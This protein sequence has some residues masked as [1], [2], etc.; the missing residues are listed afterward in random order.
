MVY[1]LVFVDFSEKMVLFKGKYKSV[2]Y[3]EIQTNMKKNTGLDVFD[4]LLS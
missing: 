2:M 1:C 4:L 3:K